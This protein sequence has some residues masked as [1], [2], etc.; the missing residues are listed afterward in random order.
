MILSFNSKFNSFYTVLEL[1]LRGAVQRALPAHQLFNGSF[2]IALFVDQNYF[3]G[4][5]CPEHILKIKVP[6]TKI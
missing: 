2:I 5:E 3:Q 6:D 4:F 1:P